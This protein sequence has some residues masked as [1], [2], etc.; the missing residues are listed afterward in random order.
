MLNMKFT[1]DTKFT[2]ELFA[3]SF[4]LTLDMYRR[5]IKTAKGIDTKPEQSRYI[6]RL[7]EAKIKQSDV[8]SSKDEFYFVS[9]TNT[10]AVCSIMQ[11]APNKW[12]VMYN[13]DW[14]HA[15]LQVTGK[16]YIDYAINLAKLQKSGAL[17]PID[18]RLGKYQ[19]NGKEV[20]YRIVENI[21]TPIEQVSPWRRELLE[22]QCKTLAIDL[23]NDMQQLTGIE[24]H[25]F[26]RIYDE[27][28]RR[29]QAVNDLKIKL[30]TASQHQ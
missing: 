17:K 18:P 15:M 8:F 27:V 10:T 3:K 20:T 28:L 25:E 23:T 6:E 9:D 4:K 11:F 5:M 30:R 14:F 1:Y 22:V 12:L 21:N 7:F 13:N 19:Y 29:Q 16:A 24:H 26:N 2:D